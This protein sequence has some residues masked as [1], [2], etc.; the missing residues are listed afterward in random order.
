MMSRLGAIHIDSHDPARLARFWAGLLGREH[1]G[2]DGGV[3]LPG[4]GR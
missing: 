2:H 4:D 3:S 1:V